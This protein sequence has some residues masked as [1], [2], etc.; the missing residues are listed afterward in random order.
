MSQVWGDIHS[1]QVRIRQ[2]ETAMSRLPKLQ[3]IA[4]EI[5]RI[6]RKATC[7]HGLGLFTRLDEFPPKIVTKDGK[8]YMK[9][10]IC[11]AETKHLDHDRKY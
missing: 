1:R 5:R 8:I 9:C 4:K 10:N 3:E 6:Y 11:G 2:N 7:G